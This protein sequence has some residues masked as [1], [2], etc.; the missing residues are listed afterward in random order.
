[1]WPVHSAAWLQPEASAAA[2][3]WTSLNIERRN[4]IPSPDFIRFPLDPFPRA[5]AIHAVR[6]ALFPSARPIILLCDLAPLGWD[7]RAASPKKESQ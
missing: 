1:M 2:P 7:A 5:A 3:S 4:R 6:E